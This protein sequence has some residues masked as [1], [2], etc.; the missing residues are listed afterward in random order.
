HVVNQSLDV[1][2][3][4]AE[5]AHRDLSEPRRELEVDLLERG[6]RC[7]FRRRGG[8]E[9]RLLRCPLRLGHQTRSVTRRVFP[10]IAVTLWPVPPLLMVYEMKKVPP[11]HPPVF[12]RSAT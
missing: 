5:V 3:R 7:S 10:T 1:G 8:P 4:D 12:P 11:P 9:L 6:Q 2:C